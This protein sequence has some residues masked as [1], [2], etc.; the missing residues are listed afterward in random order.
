MTVPRASCWQSKHSSEGAGSLVL[1]FEFCAAL[2]CLDGKESR[3]TQ[4]AEN[5][6]DKRFVG[7]KKG[8]VSETRLVF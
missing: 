3:V 6:L 1:K 5:L 2:N 7:C 4:E 8:P